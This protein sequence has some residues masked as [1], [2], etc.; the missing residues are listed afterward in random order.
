VIEVPGLNW[1]Y[2]PQELTIRGLILCAFTA[3]CVALA[4]CGGGD[5]VTGTKS[6]SFASVSTGRGVSCAVT[7]AG[8]AYCWGNSSTTPVAVAPSLTFAA[9]SAGD[10]QHVCGITR[11]GVAYCWGNDNVPVAVPGGFV[12]AAIGTEAGHGRRRDVLLGRQRIR[13][14]GQ[15]G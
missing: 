4:A 10:A 13:A 6:L 2:E 9:L 12:F 14:A 8:G 5:N 1:T 11:A 3:T 7:R 15:P